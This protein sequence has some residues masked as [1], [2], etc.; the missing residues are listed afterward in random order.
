[1][2]TILRRLIFVMMAVLVSFGVSAQVQQ[3]ELYTLS[4]SVVDENGDA[5]NL[6]TVMAHAE[7]GAI[8]DGTV[9]DEAGMWSMELPAGNYRIEASFVG[10]SANNV[11]QEI[12]LRSDLSLEP[13]VLVAGME[14]EALQVTAQLLKREADRYVLDV[15]NN[16]AA[17]AGQNTYEMLRRAPGVWADDNGITINGRGGAMVQIGERILQ[18]MSAEEIAIYLRSIPA[19]NIQKI[20]VI[21]MA[22]ADYDASFGGG[23]VKITLK[24]MRDVGVEG[25]VAFNS[26]VGKDGYLA[27]QPSLRLSYNNGSLNLY[28]MGSL[29]KTR[30]A[31]TIETVTDYE[32]GEQMSSRGEIGYE[33]SF[34]VGQLGAI[35]TINERNSLGAEVNYNNARLNEPTHSTSSLLSKLS[36]DVAVNNVG[37]FLGKTK[38]DALSATFN[39]VRV[40]DTLG[41][42][43]KL[44]GDYSS[45]VSATATDYTNRKTI[46]TIS[47]DSL[48]RN[49]SDI[50]YRIMTLSASFDKRMPRGATLR[51]GAKYTNNS[52]LSS[53][54]YTA[55]AADGWVEL[56]RMSSTTDFSEQI[57]A[58]YAIY[59]TSL[60]RMQLS[61]GMRGEYLHLHP[62]YE[63]L[64]QEAADVDRS[65]LSLFPTLNLTLPLNDVGSNMMAFSASRKVSYPS[66]STLNP[67]RTF[68]SEYSA[69]E[70]NPNLKPSYTTNLSL[71]TILANRYTID[72]GA[73]FLRDGVQQTAM[74]DP[75]DHNMLLYKYMNMDY[76]NC[77][78]MLNAP[79]QV[80]PWW[81]LNA[82]LVGLHEGT[83]LSDDNS[84]RRLWAGQSAIVSQM[85]L[86]RNW[87]IELSAG[88]LTGTIM[89]NQEV[90][91]IYTSSVMIKKQ[92]FDRRLNI[93]VGVQNPIPFVQRVH[94]VGNGFEVNAKQWSNSIGAVSFAISYNFAAGKQFRSARVESGAAEERARMGN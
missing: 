20:E 18:N 37:E 58:L 25:S 2:K 17:A 16:P 21:P 13:L 4:G 82:T 57:G 32:N 80:T 79:F 26:G 85:S 84:L 14:I 60:G 1:M 19:D 93:S 3:A 92:M 88:Y 34:P 23:V 7:D 8:A 55:K 69:V 67:Q 29:S 59:N 46:A 51:L 86:P 94:S 44:I 40:T 27:L 65:F 73:S 38:R 78:L 28:G 52:I 89:S 49:E 31:T 33:G 11:S 10:Y 56:P 90:K 6:A 22:G 64:D 24:R 54:L 47:R 91:N 5:L 53:N 35:W 9:T 12:A 76:F 83:R 43:F 15:A 81:T 30:A 39:Y 63:G 62:Q 50:D 74:L 45:N 87:T 48:Y 36:P 68:I 42:T 66:F 71:T 77:Y 72:L 70:G 61:V 75:E 41:S